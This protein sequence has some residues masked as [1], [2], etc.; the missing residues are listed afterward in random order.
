M[1]KDF[2]SVP[3]LVCLCCRDQNDKPMP[4]HSYLIAL[5]RQEDARTSQ[6]SHYMKYVCTYSIQR[7]SNYIS[8]QQH[9]KHISM[10]YSLVLYS[11]NLF[12]KLGY[13]IEA[14]S[15][16]DGIYKQEAFPC[17][18]VLLSHSTEFL[19]KKRTKW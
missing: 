1:Y 3:T 17:M 19:T 18:H 15:V 14:I 2:V 12:M 11:E 9:N 16:N 8:I 7:D 4:I 10:T 5:W 13:L 6:T